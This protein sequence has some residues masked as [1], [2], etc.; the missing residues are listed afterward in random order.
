M[1]ALNGIVHFITAYIFNQPFI[2]LS[3]VAM[4]GLI[5][6]KKPLQD[7][8]T[9]SL[10]TGIGYLILSQGTSLLAG[11]VMPI[12]DILNQIFHVEASASGIGQVA[13]EADWASSIALIMV[14]GFAVNL[15]LAR[16]TKFK[17][18][19]LTAHQTYFI[20]LVYLALAVEVIA[21]PNKTMLIVAGGILLGVYCT[22]SPALV[23]PFMRK[24]TGTNDLAYGHTTSFGVIMGALVGRAFRKYEKES[25]EELKIP[26][27][28][29]FLKDITVSTAIIMTLLYLI[30]VTLAGP[31]WV[32]EQISGGTA[33]Y[34]YAI[35]QGVMFGVG[36]TIVLTGVSMMIAEITEAFKGISEKIVPDAVPALDCP[37]VFNFAPTAVMLG[38]LSCLTTVILCVVLFGAVGFYAL[39]P[40]VITCFFGG[41]PAG[42][43]GNSTGGWR[44]AVLAGVT[45]G[46]LLSFGQALTVSCLPT[47][48]ADFARWSND[49]DYSVFTWPFQQILKLFF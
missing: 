36:I 41:G 3:L 40:P 21:S 35:S 31:A 24:V 12:A 20:A 10:K 6:Q 18:V 39:T 25:S 14:V 32:Q 19:Y 48:I 30:G 28:L 4:A 22:L 7:V 29:S 42:V 5:L 27:K 2:L 33:A 38:F 43:F 11:I 17:Y 45:A 8:I 16:L 23:Q 9:G 13:F 34:M 37:V 49:F 15:L 46:L 44:G 26:E 1:V 47:T